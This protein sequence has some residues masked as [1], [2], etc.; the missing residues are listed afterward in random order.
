MVGFEAGGSTD[1]VGGWDD[2]DAWVVMM[3]EDEGDDRAEDRIGWQAW[4]D[5]VH[6]WPETDE[7]E[8]LDGFGRKT[9]I[10][11]GCR[12]SKDRVKRTRKR[13]RRRM[14]RRRRM[15]LMMMTMMVMMM[16]GYEREKGQKE[17]KTKMMV[18]KYRQDR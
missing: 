5:E 9:R 1:G 16:N 11:K 17:G 2:E 4:D 7:R 15:I 14:K 10:W 3:M 12:G 13:K 8:E 6:D 18:E